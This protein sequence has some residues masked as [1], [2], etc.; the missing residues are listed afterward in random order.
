MVICLKASPEEWDKVNQILSIMTVDI[1]SGAS[2]SDFDKMEETS[3]S[4]TV[5]PVP[6]SWQHQGA[7]APAKQAAASPGTGL[8]MVL[9]RA[10][11]DG[12]AKLPS[13]DEFLKLADEPIEAPA[14]QHPQPSSSAI[15]L[16]PPRQSDL[17]SIIL[18]QSFDNP[19]L[20]SALEAKPLSAAYRG[21][22]RDAKGQ[23]TPKKS[24]KAT[25]QKSSKKVKKEP[26]EQVVKD[27]ELQLHCKKRKSGEVNIKM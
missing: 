12:W 16:Q 25:P 17:V 6:L 27:E 18:L 15:I 3:A 7:A 24:T 23:A 19:D 13:D 22:C 4:P 8:D 9:Y 20:A 11:A 21:V 1:V 10:H 14:V 26:K 2:I 5:P